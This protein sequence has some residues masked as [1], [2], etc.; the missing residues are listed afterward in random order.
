MDKSL[1]ILQ[2]LNWFLKPISDFILF[3]FTTKTGV[4]LLILSLVSFFAIILYNKLKQRSLLYKSVSSTSKVP[5]TDFFA[6]LAEELAKIFAKIIS[7]L[8]VLVVVLFLMLAIVGLSNTFTTF[9]NYFTN[10]KEI[11]ELSL[12]LKNL[13][14]KYKVAKVEIL[15]YS[16]RS[17]TT[18]FKI[19]FF[20]YASNNYVPQSQIITL[21]GHDI[22][23]LTHV[24]NFAYSEIENGENINIAIPYQVFSEKVA[25]NNGI[26]LNMSDNDGVPYIFHR[27]SA[28]LYGVQLNTYNQSM[29]Q[30]AQY[31]N[32]PD[33]ARQAGIRS[34]Y[35]AAPHYVK[36]LRRGQTFVIWIEQTGGLVIKQ[37][38]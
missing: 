37:D 11:K 12:V 21:P 4:F 26:R 34:S 22:Y 5:I 17:D 25:Q 13:N 30:I 24:M 3:L 20:D 8:T 18:T 31:M 16:P 2:K 36:A 19:E 9:N 28:D 15:E 6:I 33:L 29:L 32:N 35:S 1:E 38:D 14:Q 7:N 23:F 27:D 10:Q